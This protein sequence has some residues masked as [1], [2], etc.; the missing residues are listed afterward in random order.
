MLSVLSV[1]R[2][3][4]E[5]TVGVEVTVMVVEGAVMLEKVK[6]P[7]LNVTTVVV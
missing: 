4:D 6:D 7:G 1:L 3:S 5:I 2:D